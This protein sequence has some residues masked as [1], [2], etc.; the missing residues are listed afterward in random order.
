MSCLGDA[1]Q[2]Q[3]RRRADYGDMHGDTDIVRLRAAILN[4]VSNRDTRGSPHLHLHEAIMN[5]FRQRM[6]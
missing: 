2:Q 6:R 5:A 4:A 1:A 3:I